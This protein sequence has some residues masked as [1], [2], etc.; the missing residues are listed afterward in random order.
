MNPAKSVGEKRLNLSATMKSPD[1]PRVEPNSPVSSSARQRRFSTQ[2]MHFAVL[3]AQC[4]AGDNAAY[5][6]EKAA[7][8]T[9]WNFRSPV[10]AP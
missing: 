9:S 1:T 2:A 10:D 4:G 7:A 3:N 6:E 5:L 8:V